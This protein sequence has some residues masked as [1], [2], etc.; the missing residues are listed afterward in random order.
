MRDLREE[1]LF[2]T[3]FL[4]S[5]GL[6]AGSEGNLSVRTEEGFFI[7]PSGRIKET[8]TKKDLAFIN[9]KGETVIGVPSSEWGLHYKTY[10]KVPQAN[11]IVHTHPPYVLLLDRGNFSFREFFHPEANLIMKKLSKAPYF[12]PGS[13][14]LWDFAS[15]LSV[16]NCLVIL[17]R[18]GVLS[19]GR[20]LEE[21]V[22]LTLLL[23]KLCKMEYYAL[24]EEK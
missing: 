12:P 16:N 13:V 17:S 8:L 24:K 7:T 15:N 22:N 5:K 23:E 14:K 20:S 9:W 2:W 3:K 1:L 10:L 4:A 6:L 19:W 11:A 21:A 18:H